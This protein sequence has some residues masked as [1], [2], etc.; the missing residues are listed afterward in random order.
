MRIKLFMHN[1]S[2]MEADKQMCCGQNKTHSIIIRSLRLL[3]IFDIFCKT[4][5]IYNF[6][7]SIIIH[8]EWNTRWLCHRHY[9]F[10]VRSYNNEPPNRLF[11]ENY[12]L[13][14][15]V[16]RSLDVRSRNVLLNSG[17]CVPILVLIYFHSKRHH[18]LC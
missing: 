9:K 8:P 13:F 18:F 6:V 3:H 4:E 14:W 11:S 17:M 7:Y 16:F 12:L 10:L 2:K 1:F 15:L 5:R